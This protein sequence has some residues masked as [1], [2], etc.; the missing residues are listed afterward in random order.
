MTKRPGKI[1]QNVFFITQCRIRVA[2][3]YLSHLCDQGDHDQGDG[4]IDHKG[5]QFPAKSA[6]K[7]CHYNGL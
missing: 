1:L 4:S 6:I 2:S 3:D 5:N 7:T